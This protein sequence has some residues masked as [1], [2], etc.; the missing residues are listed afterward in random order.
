M[1]A[2]LGGIKLYLVLGF[3]AALT[4]G[5]AW[6]TYSA[7]RDH[8]GAILAQQAAQRTQEVADANERAHA[9]IQD[10]MH[11][12]DL[13]VAEMQSA[14]AKRQASANQ[15]RKEVLRA[16]NGKACVS[17]GPVRALLSGMRR[18]QQALGAVPGG[19]APGPRG[20]AD[21]QRPAGNPR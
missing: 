10:A 1:M 5:T 13:Q 4:A 8:Y 2:A 6:V 21:V 16:P 17:S 20:T 11:Q 19:K 7:T 15:T 9:L 18:D 3:L 12:A 14:M